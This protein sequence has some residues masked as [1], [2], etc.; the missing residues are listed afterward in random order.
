MLIT[1]NDVDN[2]L[3]M[4]A[5]SFQNKNAPLARPVQAIKLSMFWPLSCIAGYTVAVLWN[6]YRFEP[7]TGLFGN[8]T[9]ITGEYG[10]MLVAWGLSIIFSIFIFAGLYGPAL[11]YLTISEA[12]KQK[13]IVVASLKRLSKKLIFYTLAL[14]L[15]T[16]V[17]GMVIPDILVLS[18]ALIAISFLIMQGVISA[19][20]TRYGLG[21]LLRKMSN[22]TNKI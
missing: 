11:A 12:A 7:T 14:N 22:L 8:M 10:Y 13:S 5:E 1:Q 19:E 2:D 16:A 9:S 21:S 6:V 17:V 4:L 20:I 18:P 3:R 15:L